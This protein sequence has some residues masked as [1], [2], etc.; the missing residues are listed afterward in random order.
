MGVGDFC[1]SE[2]Q[3]LD[4][5]ADRLDPKAVL[6]ARQHLELCADCRTVVSG[7]TSDHDEVPG[8]AWHPQPTL[9][10]GHV[11][12]NRYRLV[13]FIGR[14]GMGEV[15]EAEDQALGDRIALKTLKAEVASSPRL[16]ARLKR[17][18]QLARKVTHPNVCRVFDLGY[19][20]G[21]SSPSQLVFLTM[22]L[23]PGET[24]RQRLL[25]AG[26]LSTAEALPIVRQLASALGAAHAAGVIHRD[27]KS[28]N[29]ILLEQPGGPRAVLTDFGLARAVEPTDPALSSSG[30]LIGTA[31]YMAPEQ[32]ESGPITSAVDVYALGVVMFELT[33]GE[34]P[35]SGTSALATA[36]DRLRRPPRSPRSIVPEIGLRWE[37]AILMCL[38]PS[39]QRRFAS[40]AALAD[41]LAPASARAQRRRWRIGRSAIAALLAAP[42]AA[43]ALSTVRAWRQE[44]AH[45][46]AARAA[47][48]STTGTDAN[49]ARAKQ[50]T[51]EAATSYRLRHFEEALTAFESAYRLG[52]HP[53]VLFN[54]ADCQRQLRRYDEAQRSY[55]AFLRESRNMSDGDAD[56]EQAR[57]FLAEMVAPAPTARPMMTSHSPLP[58]PTEKAVIAP[59]AAAARAIL[60]VRADAADAEV[61]IDG[62]AVTV[63]NG[64][65][66]LEV[67]AARAHLLVVTAP[68]RS[69]WRKSVAVAGGRALT[70]RAR[71]LARSPA[72]PPAPEDDV[73]DVFKQAN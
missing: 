17:E 44:R 59:E 62:V 45:P 22:E 72:A 7:A 3:V 68:G 64:F 18:V 21:G 15:Y 19:H 50:L 20:P 42:L 73:V 36:I 4:L 6:A 43:G 53:S 66:R 12:A 34:R 65:A 29:V 9:P 37:A 41:A 51:D 63:V 5:L 49:L 11:L 32:I 69:P 14:G 71:L 70:V 40:V 26:R 46:T 2:D 31:A 54:I 60:T 67:D 58:S 13:R 10:P 56:R 48:S 30:A 28:D 25:R 52:R 38:E 24:L 16:G 57:K 23:L 39:P 33:T 27:F 55:Q 1:L 61:R 47:D 8:F 35:F